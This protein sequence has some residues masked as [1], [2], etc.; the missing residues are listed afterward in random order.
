MPEVYDSTLDGAE[1]FLVKIDDTSGYSTEKLHE[2]L[3]EALVVITDFLH[4]AKR[5]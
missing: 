1:E 5:R 3:A 2:L 4:D